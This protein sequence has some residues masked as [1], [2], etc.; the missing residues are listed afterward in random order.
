MNVSHRQVRKSRQKR[1]T[2]IPSCNSA[3]FCDNLFHLIV[4]TTLQ[5]LYYYI[6]N[7]SYE[8]TD[9]IICLYLRITNIF[10][11]MCH[12][13]KIYIYFVSYARSH[14]SC[15]QGLYLM[16]L[17]FSALMT[18]DKFVDSYRFQPVSEK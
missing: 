18:W 14:A 13:F 15:G 4:K 2:H 12:N 16:A 10:G 8:I 6:S 1:R 9:E 7:F 5:C 3:A 17:Y 11:H